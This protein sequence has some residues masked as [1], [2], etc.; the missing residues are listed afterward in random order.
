MTDHADSQVAQP[1]VPAPPSSGSKLTVQKIVIIAAAVLG[2][3]IILLFLIGLGFA[4]LG[5]A[6]NTAAVIQVIRDIVIIVMALEFLVI[7]AALA[8]L[9]LQ[10][11][12]LVNLLQNEVK[13]VLQNTQEAVNSAK[14]TVE[15]VGNNVTQPFIRASGFLAG[16][17]VLFREVGGIRR[18]IRPTKEKQNGQQ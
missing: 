9:I 11:A 3:I 14:G 17:G 2:G 13:P 16:V 12:R 10:I 1:P 6:Q 15:F 18:A 8:I 7:I 4:L 5:N